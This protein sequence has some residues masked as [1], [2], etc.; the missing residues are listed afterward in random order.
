[1]IHIKSNKQQE[2][3]DAWSFLSPKRRQMLDDDWPGLFRE[4]LLDELPV[5]RLASCFANGMGRPTKELYT[6]LGALLL[7]QTMDFN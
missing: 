7:Q 1:M 2:L 6:V 3:F 4:H 5:N